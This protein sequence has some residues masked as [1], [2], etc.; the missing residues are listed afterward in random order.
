MWPGIQETTQLFKVFASRDIRLENPTKSAILSNITRL[1]DPLGLASAVTIKARIAMQEIWKTRKY[2]CDDPL[3]EETHVLWGRIF[4]D[5]KSLQEIEI[6]RCL[7]PDGVTGESEVDMFA[8]ASES[9]YGSVAYLLWPTV[10]GPQVNLI[11]AK[12]RVAP[13]RQSTIPRLELMAALIAARLATTL[14]NEL[15]IKPSDTVL[16]SDPEIMLRW[17]RSESSSLKTFAG[18]REAEIQSSWPANHWRHVP[19]EENP[20]DDL[21]R[22]ICVDEMIKG[23][24]MSG[25]PFLKEP[26]SEWPVKKAIDGEPEDEDPERRRTPFPTISAVVQIKPLLDP[27][28]H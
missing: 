10:N 19:T 6:P 1:Y 23:R 26:K 4:Q 15:K 3:S 2:D 16:W 22:R 7:K 24:W 8:D 21:S 13:L 11:S 17:L 9:A 14:N 25:R 27:T 5:I 12:A 20:A 18:V 28:A